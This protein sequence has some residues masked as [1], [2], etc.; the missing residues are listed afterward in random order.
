MIIIQSAIIARLVVYRS[1][2]SAA[3]TVEFGEQNFVNLRDPDL[4]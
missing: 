2:S 3:M 1:S 4:S